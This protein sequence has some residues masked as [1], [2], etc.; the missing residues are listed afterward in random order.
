[1]KLNG[2]CCQYDDNVFSFIFLT[3]FVLDAQTNLGPVC[4]LCAKNMSVQAC[5]CS[6]LETTLH[7]VR[8][9][10]GTLGRTKLLFE[11]KIKIRLCIYNFTSNRPV[12]RLGA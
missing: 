3:L 2:D 10:V 5:P 4:T 9:R 6:L 11:I 1:M 8:W 7:F 12:Y